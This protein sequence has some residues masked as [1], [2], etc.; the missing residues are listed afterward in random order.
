MEATSR[1]TKA[2]PFDGIWAPQEISAEITMQ[3]DRPDLVKTVQSITRIHEISF[4]AHL[5]ESLFTIPF[6]SLPPNTAVS[7]ARMGIAYRFGDDVMIVDGQP[8]QL[9]EKVSHEIKAED[10]KQLLVGAAPIIDPEAP[11]QLATVSRPGSRIWWYSIA[12]V[13]VGVGLL[14][15]RKKSARTIRQAS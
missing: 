6:D 4:P 3:V 13:L 15:W 12:L 7:D 5:D 14:V 8:Y 2:A 1:V 11:A 9:T 10:L